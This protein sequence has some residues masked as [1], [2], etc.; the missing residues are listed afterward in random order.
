MAYQRQRVALLWKVTIDGGWLVRARGAVRMFSN[1]RT[2]RAV[3][4]AA[5]LRITAPLRL[6]VRSMRRLGWGIADQGMSSLTNFAVV[7]LVARSLGAVDFGAFSLAYVTYGFALNV[8][9]GLA[10]YP[11]QVR[12][13]SARVEK[14][15]QAVADCSATALATGIAAGVCVLAVAA[16][17]RGDTR[18]TLVALGLTLPGLLLQD[19]WRYAFF[20]ASRGG[21]AFLNDSVW[22]AAQIPAILLLRLSGTRNVFWFVLAWGGA[23][24]VAAA[25]GLLQARVLP[26]LQGIRHWLTAHRDLG[27]RYAGSNLMASLATQARSSILAGMLGLAVVG[28]VQAAGTLLGPFMVIFYGIGLVTVPEGVRVLHRAPTRLPFF[29][30]VVACGLAIAALIW[31]CLLLVALPRGLGNLLLGSIWHS[32]YALVVPATVG[33]VG[34]AFSSGA[35]TGLSALGA[36]KRD[37]RATTIGSVGFLVCGVVGPLM[38]GALGT[39]IGAAISAWLGAAL[40]WWEFR[41]AILELGLTRTGPLT[42]LVNGPS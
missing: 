42:K 5:P 20:V 17:L 31:G 22:A 14:W 6:G 8:S 21:H 23:A 38:G 15:R 25:V 27:A 34:Q 12:F 37:L 41:G 2:R 32:T 40:F 33:V 24:A 35:A 9:R 1:M 28:Y 3:E 13:S 29:C 4:K 26:N 11:L 36:A 16:F 10:S 18:A 39:M 30:T 19:N 7:I